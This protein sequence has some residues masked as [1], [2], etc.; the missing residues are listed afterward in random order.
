MTW[1][2]ERKSELARL[3]LAG[4]TYTQIAQ[5]LGMSR[6]SMSREVTRLGLTRR[7]LP[8]KWTMAEDVELTRQWRAGRSAVQI[9]LALDRAPG[10]ITARLHRLRLVGGLNYP[11][12]N[13]EQS[14]RPVTLPQIKWLDHRNAA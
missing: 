3:Y 12:Q 4:E 14:V 5:A 2:K 6:G 8:P 1:T 13:S 11:R 10:A 7:P 9:A